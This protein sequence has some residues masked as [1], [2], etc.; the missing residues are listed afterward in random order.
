MITAEDVRHLLAADQDAVL[1]VIEGRVDIVAPSSLDTDAYRGA[2]QL[3]TRA[4]VVA[5]RGE[6]LSDREVAEQAAALDS[7]LSEL[8][9]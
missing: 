4:D 1:V 8:G 3:I 2:L 9:G 7:A 6:E 5:G